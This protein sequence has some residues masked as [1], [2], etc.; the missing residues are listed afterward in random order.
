MFPPASGEL[1]P[2]ELS[3][4]VPHRQVRQLLAEIGSLAVEQKATAIVGI[5]PIS[6]ELVAFSDECGDLLRRHRIRPGKSAGWYRRCGKAQLFTSSREA[7][8]CTC[9]GSTVTLVT[10]MVMG[11][12]I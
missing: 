11:G 10:N 2:E 8:I 12:S 4:G 7:V 6:A 5:W 1:F 3:H 9:I